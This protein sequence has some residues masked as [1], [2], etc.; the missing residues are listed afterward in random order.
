MLGNDEVFA[1]RYRII[2]K[3]A[4]GGMGVVYEARH[5]ET[6]RPVALK[7]MLPQFAGN[8][9]LRERFRREARRGR[10][11]QHPRR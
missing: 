4:T 5:I 8:E 1:N 2:R 11:L 9:A 6:A 3:I 7:V 10:G